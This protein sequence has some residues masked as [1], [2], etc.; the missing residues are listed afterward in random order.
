MQYKVHGVPKPGKSQRA[1]HFPSHKKEGENTLGF[2]R[3]WFMP[4]SVSFLLGV[5]IVLLSS[6]TLAFLVAFFHLNVFDQ[7]FSCDKIIM[8]WSIAAFTKLWK[9]P[10]VAVQIASK[11]KKVKC[12]QPSPTLPKILTLIFYLNEWLPPCSHNS[13][14]PCIVLRISGN[15]FWKRSPN[16]WGATRKQLAEAKRTKQGNSV[17]VW[18]GGAGFWQE[19]WHFCSCVKQAPRS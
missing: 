11:L 13:S 7:L 5:F 16:H 1:T 10:L 6:Y 8:K 3:P 12:F 14:K 4:F 15:P 9:T 2:I 19:V 18:G 17:S